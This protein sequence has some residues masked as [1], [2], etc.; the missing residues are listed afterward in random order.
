[1]RNDGF[2]FL[3]FDCDVLAFADLIAFDLIVTLD[4]LTGLGVNVFAPNAM[5][6]RPIDGV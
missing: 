4:R 1:M 3:R 6:G 2:D 5:A